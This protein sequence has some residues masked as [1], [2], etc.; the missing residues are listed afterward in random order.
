MAAGAIWPPMQYGHRCSAATGARWP[1]KQYGH[2][3]IMV[4]GA[5]WPPVQYGHRC[6]MTTGARWPLVQDGHRYRLVSDTI[7]PPM[8]RGHWCKMATDA[9]WPPVQ[10]GLA[11]YE[12]QM[13]KLR[14]EEMIGPAMSKTS[15]CDIIMIHQRSQVCQHTLRTRP[16]ACCARTPKR[17]LAS[18]S[19]VPASSS[20]KK[21]TNSQRRILV[22]IKK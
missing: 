8:H 19:L 17:G 4:R 7:W 9:V 13:K 3:C 21:C 10:C 12:E 6:S 22:G 15:A 20:K 1:P 11:V 5:M 18:G 16:H 14:P 2:R